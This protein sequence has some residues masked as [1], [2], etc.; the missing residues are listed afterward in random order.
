MFLNYLGQ[1]IV[2]G[3]HKKILCWDARTGTGDDLMCLVNL[4]AE[5]NSMSLSGFDVVVA[6][7]TSAYMYDLRNISKSFHSEKSDMDVRI[8]CVSSAPHLKGMCLNCFP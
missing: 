8:K 6:V 7:G 1:L 3:S 4:E 2:S 5:V